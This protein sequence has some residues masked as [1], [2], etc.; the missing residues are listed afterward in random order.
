M[1]LVVAGGDYLQIWR[2]AMNVLNKQSR[3]ADK[4]QSFSSVVGQEANNSSS[5]KNKKSIL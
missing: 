5:Q 4:E 1:F 3:T 2:V